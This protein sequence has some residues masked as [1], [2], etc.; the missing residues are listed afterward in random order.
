MRSILRIAS[1]FLFAL[2]R[3]LGTVGWLGGSGGG[4]GLSHG[5]G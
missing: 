2:S 1:T 3:A 4:P 5:S